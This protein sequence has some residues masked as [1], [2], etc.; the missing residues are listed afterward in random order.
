MIFKCGTIFK[1]KQKCLVICIPAFNSIQVKCEYF[2][3]CFT[4]E[5]IVILCSDNFGS[6]CIPEKV[7]QYDFPWR[8]K[9]TRDI[10]LLS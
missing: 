2:L 7:S 6:Q 3:V 5:Q 1:Q 10:K 8:L 9:T 4:V